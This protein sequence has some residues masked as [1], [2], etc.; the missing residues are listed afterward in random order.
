MKRLFLLLI[1]GVFMTGINAQDY[2]PTKEDLEKFYKTKT[3]VVLENNPLLQYNFM[4]KDVIEREWTLTDYEFI[5]Y[6]EFE[7][8]R[9]N[10]DYS[11]LILTEVTFQKDKTDARYNFLHLLL[12]GD[13]F[14]I[15]EMPAICSVPLSYYGVEEDSYIYKLGVLVRFMQDHVKMIYENPGMISDN[16]FKHYNDNMGDIKNKSL[17]LIESE[18]S[19]DVNSARRIKSVYPYQF[20]IVT[21]DDIMKA[22]EE[23]NDDVVFLHKVGPEGTKLKARCYK[24]LIGASDA[25]FYYFDYHM[26]NSKNPDGFLEK[27]FKK[28]SRK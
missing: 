22:I 13:Y 4:I 23:K 12:G 20:K 15:N 1:A 7:D 21:A 18:L 19:T 14:R 16:V 9:T 6:R 2:I 10:P 3:Y 28:M 17:Y 27:D 25:R 26:I 24:M 5:P 8:L 11:F